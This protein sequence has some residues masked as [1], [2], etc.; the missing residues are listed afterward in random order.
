MDV[1]SKTQ[2]Q[3]EV[4]HLR[5]PNRDLPRE[6]KSAPLPRSG[7]DG[8]ATARMNEPNRWL[9]T[10]SL[11]YEDML[12]SA[13]DWL[14]ECN[15]QLVLTFV[16]EP[17]SNGRRLPPQMDVGRHLADLSDV[18][19]LDLQE[20]PIAARLEDRQTFR[21]LQVHV[22][23]ASGRSILFCMSGVP[24]Y[25][26]RNGAFLGYR[27]TGRE[28]SDTLIEDEAEE[29]QIRGDEQL[30][31]LLENALA[32]KDQLE[33]ELSRAGH[34]TFE[35][36]LAA[37]AHELRTPLNA[38]IGF[39][40]IIKTRALGDDLDRYVD[41]GGDIYESGVHMVAL[42]NNLIDLAKID[43][44]RE[45]IAEETLNLHDVV[46][47]A[48]RMLEEQAAEAG[49]KLVNHLRQDLP[50]VTGER[51]AVRQ[52][53]LNLLSNAIKYTRPGGA[54]GVEAEIN[55]DGSVSIVVWDTGIGIP[56]DEHVRIFD[57]TY[58]V[59]GEANAGK[60]GSGLGLA[61]SRDLA[62]GMG[63]DIS[64]VSKPGHGA[65]FS[66]QLP[67]ARSQSSSEFLDR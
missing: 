59:D 40:E 53:F 54:V 36:R 6:S 19:V 61:I 11:S 5:S 62:K 66:V 29:P 25:D 33:W 8:V 64:V 50:S 41:Y 30:L 21:D 27:G 18:Q 24:I 17:M 26:R 48:L 9:M 44:P 32:R 67:T 63:G 7:D 42:V 23:T 15:A 56:E 51:S 46:S 55:G 45:P 31:N 3:S 2:G 65:R 35:S 13:V 60:S 47:S 57:R 39:A 49:I 20:P 14:W 52:I 4:L 43:S 38:I 58:R 16:S 34:K 37:I 1:N 12:R 10:L 22:E 28:I